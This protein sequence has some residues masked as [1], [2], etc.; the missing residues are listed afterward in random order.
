VGDEHGGVYIKNTPPPIYRGGLFENKFPYHR[1]GSP[2]LGVPILGTPY[3]L[4][5]L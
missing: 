4:V 5:R 3:N 2:S 1:G